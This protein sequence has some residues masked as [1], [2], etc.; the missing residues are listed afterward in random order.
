MK[1]CKR[2]LTFFCHREHRELRGSI[3]FFYLCGLCGFLA[4]AWAAGQTE[5][6][7]TIYVP[8]ADLAEL[9]EPTHKAVLMEHTN[10][11]VYLLLLKPTPRQRTRLNWARSKMHGTW[12]RFQASR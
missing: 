9:I 10:S 6:K 5:D 11:S 2:L 12:Q 1:R 8:Y 3:T 7:P 4:S